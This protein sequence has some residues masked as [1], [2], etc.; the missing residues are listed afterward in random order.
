M[1]VVTNPFKCWETRAPHKHCCWRLCYPYRKQ[2]L[3]EIRC[4]CRVLNWELLVPPHSESDQVTGPVI[5]GIRLTLPIKGISMILGND[6]AGG[7]VRSDH[8]VTNLPNE[9]NGNDEKNQDLYPAYAV[10][11]A[12]AKKKLAES[13]AENLP[14]ID[15]SLNLNE[16]FI[17]NQKEQDLVTGRTQNS[18]NLHALRIM[19]ENVGHNF[20]RDRIIA[21]Q[22]N[23][24]DLIPIFKRS[25]PSG[26]ANKVSECF[27][28]NNGVLMRK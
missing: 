13:N 3:Q 28:L 27:Y 5:A 11:R 12:M 25:L 6:F 1:L 18:S 2:H 24:P 20:S 10:T 19:E 22:G 7:R 16:N 9:N 23:D 8:I 17:S 4:C 21:E 26:E 15:D 14:L